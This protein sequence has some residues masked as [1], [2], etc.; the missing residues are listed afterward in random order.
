MREMDT[1]LGF[2]AQQITRNGFHPIELFRKIGRCIGHDSRLAYHVIK[3]PGSWKCME[4]IYENKPRPF[5]KRLPGIAD[6]LFLGSKA[7]KATR[8]RKDTAA[9]TLMELIKQHAIPGD[10]FSVVSLGSGP[11]HDI[12]NALSNIHQRLLVFAT[13]IDI[14]ESALEHGRILATS[15]RLSNL[16]FVKKDISEVD[17]TRKYDVASIIGL[18]EYLSYDNSVKFLSWVRSLLKTDGRILISNMRKHALTGIMD[19]FGQWVLDY[20]LLG[21][22]KEI[23]EVAGFEV[24]KFFYEGQGLHSFVIGKKLCRSQEVAP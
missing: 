14:D 15:L 18:M 1:Q 12:I 2:G 8:N 10:E 21:E 4:V 11:A 19:F 7:C 16:E 6:R 17:N 23:T 5:N 3:N 22:L 9:T 20:K 24:E 13:C